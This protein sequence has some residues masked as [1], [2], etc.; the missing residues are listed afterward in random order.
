MPSTA[1]L[2]RRKAVSPRRRGVRLVEPLIF[3]H[4]ASFRPYSAPLRLRGESTAWI[5]NLSD[6]VRAGE[7]GG[8][9]PLPKEIFDQSSK[10]RDL[11][12]DQSRNAVSGLV[13][14]AVVRGAANPDSKAARPASTAIA[15][16]RAIRLGSFATAMAVLTRTASAPSSI[17]AEA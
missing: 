9:P 3:A 13:G 8:S 11:G 2:K 15:N 16:A 5:S 1:V 14:L 17:A 12:F 6:L 7:C 4:P 10:N